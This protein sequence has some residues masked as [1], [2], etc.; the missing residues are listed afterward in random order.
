MTGE[1]RGPTALKKGPSRPQNDRRCHGELNP[2]RDGR[3]DKMQPEHV[4]TH[5]QQQQGDAEHTRH[6]KSLRKINQF[7]I[8]CISKR[9]RFGFER[10]PANWARTRASLPDLGMHRACPHCRI[11][12]DHGRKRGIFQ[13]T[14]WVSNK[15]RL[16][17]RAAK[18]ERFV[19]DIRVVR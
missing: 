6:P 10:H 17:T 19:R 4:G 14:V 11:G 16:A 1:Q 12:H 15:L 3:A 9:R 8:G 18:M 13:I 2:R 5:R 7:G